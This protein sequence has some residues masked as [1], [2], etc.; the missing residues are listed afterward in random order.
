MLST[1]GIDVSDTYFTVSALRKPQDMIFY[2]KEWENNEAGFSRCLSFLETHGLTNRTS[3]VVM[4][5]TGVYD[6]GLCHFFYQKGFPTHREPPLAVR[7]AF[8]LKEKT[9]KVDSKM[10]A[11]Y[12]HRFSDVL[13]FWEPPDE[14]LELIAV[15]LTMREGFT[16]TKVAAKNAKTS[17]NRKHRAF[18]LPDDLLDDTIT[19]MEKRI[20]QIDQEM[21]RLVHQNRYQLRIVLLLKTAPGV[22][23]LLALNLMVVTR[24]F[25]EHLK[26]VS[27]SNYVGIC[28]WKFRSGTSV[29]KADKAAKDGLARVRKLLWLAAKS[30]KHHSPDMKAYH[31]R[32]S[33]RGKEPRVIRNNLKNKILRI[34]CAII[35]TGKP[36]LP[37]YLS[38]RDL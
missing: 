24:G 15:L 36:Y 38:E 10:I 13:H 18:A 6:E 35:A 7:R 11:E 34:C 3:R 5:A 1:V 28:P 14:M 22:D 21:K 19:E 30:V 33:R 9:D 37:G 20:K 26:Y 29:Y 32:M 23:W 27:L 4:E 8:R 25:M 17:L 16:K 2:G 31:E 12:G